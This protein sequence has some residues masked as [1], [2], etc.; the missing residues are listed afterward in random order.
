MIKNPNAMS[1]EEF[2]SRAKIKHGDK[3]EYSKSVY[4]RALTKITIIC[5]KHG[6]FKQTPH[7]HLQG[8][9][10]PNCRNFTDTTEKF[11]AKSKNLYGDIY[12]Y[13][14]TVYLG[15][16]KEVII[17]CP[18]HGEF[19]QQASSHYKA[20]C[21]KCADIKTGLKNRV[22]QEDFLI[23]SKIVHDNK[24]DY[25][26][27]VYCGNIKKITV[28][29]P[30]HGEFIQMASAHLRGNGCKLC[31]NASTRTCETPD[32]WHDMSIKNKHKFDSYKFYV[33]KLND[34]K[35][36][37][38]KFGITYRKLKQRMGEFPYNVDIYQIIEDQSDFKKI[39]EIEKL[40]KEASAQYSYIPLKK[41]KG[42]TECISCDEK[43]LENLIK[44]IDLA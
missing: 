35:E 13:S 5:H 41:F 1:Q 28:I 44:S 24:Y 10:C 14:K 15:K 43:I 20:G 3:Y 4:I 38:Y 32:R 30:E 25:S 21:K 17:I 22:S 26:K 7:M 11:I 31:A 9:G 6:E 40:F 29:C 2:L 16:N 34:G 19:K 8:Q 36:S 37:F 12:D 23:R 18:E 27:T 42:I 33:L 39:F